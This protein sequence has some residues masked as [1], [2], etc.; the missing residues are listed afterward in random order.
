MVLVQKYLF[1]LSRYVLTGK[2]TRQIIL[3]KKKNTAIILVGKQDT[4]SIW[5]ILDRLTILQVSCGGHHSN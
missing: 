3:S 2:M 1:V 4:E 5:K